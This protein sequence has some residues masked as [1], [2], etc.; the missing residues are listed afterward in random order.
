LIFGQGAAT[1][2]LVK[3]VIT[4]NAMLKLSI[5]SMIRFLVVPSILVYLAKDVPAPIALS[6]VALGMGILTVHYWWQVREA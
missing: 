3:M 2:A 5:F 1:L 4:S 6:G